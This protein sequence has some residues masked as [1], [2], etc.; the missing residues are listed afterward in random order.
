MYY[1]IPHVCFG[2][3]CWVSCSPMVVAML[4]SGCIN[5]N[6]TG[7]DVANSAWR[8]TGPSFQKIKAIPELRRNKITGSWFSTHIKS[9][10]CATD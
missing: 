9:W 2:A 1:H 6:Q 4:L 10:F 3:I 8:L 5:F 7:Q